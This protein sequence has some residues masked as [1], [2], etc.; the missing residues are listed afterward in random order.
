MKK[1]KLPKNN[2]HFNQ[3]AASTG[4]FDS[5]L[6]YFWIENFGLDQ[7]SQELHSLFINSTRLQ[8]VGKPSDGSTVIQFDDLK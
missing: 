6:D 2:T 4:H 1:F 5:K 7:A 3:V 8:I